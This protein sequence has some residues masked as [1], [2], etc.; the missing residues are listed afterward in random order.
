MSLIDEVKRVCD[1][2]APLGWRDL[3]LQHGLDITATNLKQELTKELPAIKRQIPG[4]ED[5]AFEGKRGVE[6]GNPSRSLLFHAFASP[7]VVLSTQST[8]SNAYPTLAELEIIENFVY[9]VQPPSLQ[10]LRVR[11]Q[12]QP[13]AI[14][15]FASEYRPGAETVHRKHADLCF[16][17]TGV[18]RVGTAE[19]LYDAKARGF[20]PFVES[21][22]TS[23]RVLPARYSAYIAVQ[24]QGNLN[25]FGPMR[26]Q[27]GDDSRLFWVP[28]HKLFDGTECIRNLNLQVSLLSRHIN[29]KLRR[30]HLSLKGTG[31]GEP[32]ISNPPFIFS[33]GI[34]ELSTKSEFGDGLLVPVVH[35][36][37]IQA[38]RYKDK[39]LTFRV[40]ENSA[41]L[42]SSLEIPA[43]G[44]A[45]HAPEYV[46]A[47]HRVLSN[48]QIENLNDRQDVERVV[49]AGGYDAQHYVDFT[50][51]GSVEAICPELAVA[52][53]RRIP[54][55]SLVTAPDFF[56]NCDQRELLEWTEQ[57]VP[58]ALRNNLWRV[59]PDTLSDMRLA[60]NLQLKDANFRPEDKTVTAIVSPPVTGS[61]RQMPLSGS[62]TMRHAYL[63]DAAAGVFAPGWDISTDTTAEGVNHLA[64][65]GLGSPFPEDAKL[66]AAL[67]TF[68]PAVAPDAARTFQP[69]PTWPTVSPLTDEE[70]GQV[71]NQSWDGIAGP[72]KV[73]RNGRNFIEYPDF[74]HADYVDN[75][76]QK[77]F[78]IS[79]T[80]Q[81]DVR[82]YEARVLAMA[83]VYRVLGLNTLQARGQW[84]VFSF[85]EVV[86]TD[87]EL[88]QAQTQTGTTLSGTIYRFEIYRPGNSVLS[89]E[90]VRKRLVEFTE[91]VTLFVTPINILLKRG[92]GNWSS[93]RV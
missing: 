73:T 22:P 10:D 41:T 69:S 55:Y 59:P 78:S 8:N 19:P 48:G 37:L 92:N 33:E 81:V 36:N 93:R 2:L 77:K 56:P 91:T 26:F 89:S 88:R 16:S 40:P 1:R 38:A 79:L 17:R 46:H 30:V 24:R 29:Q 44:D 80:G 4:F 76:L 34:A 70:I 50:G 58:T 28:L 84:S 57:S 71:G 5:F 53:P 42:S 62:P 20:I 86:S 21:D 49:R 23:L 68:W 11:A 61:V 15:V 12:N 72:R 43:D 64:S 25:A 67:S 74:A 54:A 60:P 66:C 39:P 7:N 90:D 52:I 75:T 87:A 85:R 6:A 18:T 82:E 47:R 83:N 45:R 65:Y 9:G 31:W 35:P 3:L 14:V 27:T 32:D 13:L 63:P 51:D